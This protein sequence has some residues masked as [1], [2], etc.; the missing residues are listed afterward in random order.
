MLFFT[1]DG[2]IFDDSIVC[3]ACGCCAFLESCINN[4]LS[5]VLPERDCVAV[6]AGFG[7]AGNCK[8]CFYQEPEESE[9]VDPF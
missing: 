5:S 3:N 6:L 8:G 7:C 2:H 1:K 9:C 4:S